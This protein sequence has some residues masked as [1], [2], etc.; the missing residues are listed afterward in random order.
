MIPT[1]TAFESSPDRGRGLAR[2]M[3]VRWALEEVGQPY[4]VRLLSFAELKQPAHRKLQPFGQIPTYEEDDL[5]LFES[6]AILLHLGERHG[7][8]LP[9]D[10]NARLRAIS[11]MF[12]ALNTIEPPVFERSMMQVLERKEPWFEARSAMVDQRVRQRF[13]EL[14]QH[15]GDADW[16]DGEFSAGDLMM[17]TVLMRADALG[18]VEEFP[19][20]AA[21]LAR[22]KARPAFQRAF[23]AQ[24]SVFQLAQ[25]RE[26]ATT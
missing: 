23:E 12:A 24:A 20:L 25:A 18:F 17:V 15:L 13:G 3:R 7:V 16:L 1:I 21:Y 8:L 11:W 22:G 9:K 26:N 10:A 14:V 19:A 6:G 4:D 2:D 5:V